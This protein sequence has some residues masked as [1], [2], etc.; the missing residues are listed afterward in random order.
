MVTR[1]DEIASGLRPDEAAALKTLEANG[2]Q[3]AIDVRIE[4]MH[5]PDGSRRRTFANRGRYAVTALLKNLSSREVPEC[6]AFP[7]VMSQTATVEEVKSE[8]VEPS[9]TW[10]ESPGPQIKTDEPDPAEA[11]ETDAGPPPAKRGPG[12][13]TKHDRG[14]KRR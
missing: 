11:G 6:L 7:A 9:M 1:F 2:W 3:I 10:I 8:E 5:K 4:D 14:G 13:P 12:R